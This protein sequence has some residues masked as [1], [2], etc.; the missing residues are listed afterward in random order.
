MD[1]SMKTLIL[2]LLDRHRI[3]TVATN[4]PDG[5]PQA[6]TVGYGNDG[7]IIYFLCGLDSQKAA[8][9]TRDNRVSVTI[10]HDTDQVMEIKGL[11][12]AAHAA[13]VTDPKEATRAMELMF[14]RYPEQKG[15]TMPLPAPEE[16]CIF[17]LQPVVISVLD[18]SKG[19]AHTD[20]V[21]C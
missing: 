7:M 8:N 17:R 11:S 12:I 2:T 9:I 20:L 21:E 6:T 13:R 1:A 16:V 10:D 18:Y 14:A 4:R 3:M 19:F 5:W 15:F